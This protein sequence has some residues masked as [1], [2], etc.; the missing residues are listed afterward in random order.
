[1][2]IPRRYALPCT[3]KSHTPPRPTAGFRFKRV[4]SDRPD[5]REGDRVRICA[6]MRTHVSDKTQE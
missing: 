5:Y 3:P 6:E 2:T 1:M 4:F